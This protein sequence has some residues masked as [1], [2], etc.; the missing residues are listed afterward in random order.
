MQI[1]MLGNKIAIEAI[2]KIKKKN[3]NALLVM[4]D[5]DDSTGV[6]RHLGEEYAGKLLVGQKVC[7]GT[8]RQKVRISGQD[9]IIMEPDNI[10]AILD[11]EISGENE[12]K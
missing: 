6:I 5:H 1:Q 4:P 12:G 7:Y 11:S 10:F 8:S 3:E 2:D 9:L